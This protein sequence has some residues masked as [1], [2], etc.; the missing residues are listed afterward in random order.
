MRR[1]DDPAVL[2]KARAHITGLREIYPTLSTSGFVDQ[3]WS[4]DELFGLSLERIL[5]TLAPPPR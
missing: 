5:D 3:A 2:D 1:L 4:D